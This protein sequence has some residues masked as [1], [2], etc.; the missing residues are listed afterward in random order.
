MEI[1]K[2]IPGYEEYYQVSNMGRIKSFHGWRGKR[3]YITNGHPNKDGYM[4][5]D[6][7]KKN[8]KRQTKSIHTLVLNAFIGIVPDKDC[9]HINGNKSDNRLENLEYCT[10]SE[11][12]FHTYNS[13]GRISPL[14]GE[15]HFKAKLSEKDVLEIKEL[16]TSGNYSK[17]EIAQMYKVTREN[18]HLIIIGKNWKHLK[19]D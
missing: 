8:D 15:K 7:R 11:N 12:V 6:L 19:T 2:D 3:E 5:I 1:W 10:K 16:Y 4:K 14:R 17:R 18:I 13:L 9:N